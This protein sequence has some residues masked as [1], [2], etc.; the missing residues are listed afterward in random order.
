MNNLISNILYVI[1]ISYANQAISMFKE[2][3]EKPEIILSTIKPL[4]KIDSIYL[5]IDKLEF[6][7][8]IELIKPT[9]SEILGGNFDSPEVAVLSEDNENRSTSPAEYKDKKIYINSVFLRRIIDAEIAD[10]S[11]IKMMMII[12]LA[13]ELIHAWQE[14]H[15]KLLQNKD[16]LLVCEGHATFYASRFA[17]IY[18][19]EKYDSH[20]QML[21]LD[22]N[23]YIKVCKSTEE[24][25]KEKVLN[26]KNTRINS[27]KFIKC[28]IE[29]AG[30]EFFT[31][32][33]K[34]SFKLPILLDILTQ[35]NYKNYINQLCCCSVIELVDDDDNNS[36]LN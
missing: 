18:N 13:H 9:L 24:E 11:D 21:F 3:P 14:Q 35:K 2:L 36:V 34:S 4:H 30:Y 31:N 28:F 12:V 6:G 17:Q 20:G 10:L 26:F 32:F 23:F 1:L 16:G 33:I 29:T 22:K 7:R 8:A 19:I 25:A 15:T 5:A 27:S